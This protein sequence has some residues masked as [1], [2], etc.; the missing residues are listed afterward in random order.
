MGGRGRRKGGREGGRVGGWEEGREGKEE[1]MHDKLV[2]MYQHRD[3]LL[4]V[5]K[6]QQQKML[7]VSN[8]WRT[9]E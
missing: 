5:H 7:V 2:V 4:D 1:G 6:M 9:K 8:D 3:K